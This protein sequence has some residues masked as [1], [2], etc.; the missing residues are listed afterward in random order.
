MGS[1]KTLNEK[2]LTKKQ[3]QE[4]IRTEGRLHEEYTKFFEESYPN[5]VKRDKVY[6]LAGDRFLYVFDENGLMI[7][8]KGDIYPKDYFLRWVKRIQRIREDSQAGR[9][10]SVDHWRYYSKY[11]ADI[12]NHVDSLVNELTDRLKIERN[13]L[14]KSYESLDLVSEECEKYGLENIFENLYDN[15]VIYVGEVIKDRVNGH[16]AI[17]ETH[18]GGDYPFISIDLKSVQYMPINAA[19]SAMDGLAPV[20][21]RK[22]VANELRQTSLRA[23]YQRQLEKIKLFREK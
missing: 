2:R 20:D 22:E 14:D 8:G 10:S 4:I 11:K 3:V 7:P 15:V 16:W 21:F 12:I 13:K 19:W 5:F 23:K 17:N 1:K 18:S 9:F 6:E